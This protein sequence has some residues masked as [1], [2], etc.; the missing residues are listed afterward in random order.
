NGRAVKYLTQHAQVAHC[1]LAPFCLG[2][3]LARA[4]RSASDD[5]AMRRASSIWVAGGAGFSPCS[6]GDERAV[7]HN[8]PSTAGRSFGG[9]FSGGVSFSLP[10]IL[11]AR[12]S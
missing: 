1:R 5:A 2:F 9:N 8:Y 3:L 10:S 7:A 4:T 11:V 6:S 12:H